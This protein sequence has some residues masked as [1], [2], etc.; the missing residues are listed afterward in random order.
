MLRN[1]V[2]NEPIV[3]PVVKKFDFSEWTDGVLRANFK[4]LTLKSLRYRTGSRI[5]LEVESRLIPIEKEMK[6]RGLL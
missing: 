3:K 2:I 6:N 1:Y 5:Y 4:F